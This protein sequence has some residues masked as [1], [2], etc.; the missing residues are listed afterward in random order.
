ML[1]HGD[2][3]A[4]PT[5]L[6]YVWLPAQNRAL[7]LQLEREKTKVAKLQQALSIAAASSGEK[8]ST[9]LACIWWQ[10]VSVETDAAAAAGTRFFTSLT[11]LHTAVLQ[12]ASDDRNIGSVEASAG[13]AREL[14]IN[15]ERLQQMTT[16]LGTMEQK[17]AGHQHCSF[18]LW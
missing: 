16:R 17:V 10:H 18:T 11:A 14:A 1:V 12:V 2:T 7:N 6:L 4:L 5:G 3:T 9:A 13:I 15:R 8:A